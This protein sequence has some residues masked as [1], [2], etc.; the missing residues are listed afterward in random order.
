VTTSDVPKKATFFCEGDKS[1]EASFF[2]G[3]DEG[4]D[5]KLSDG[6][7]LSIP[8]AWSA[9]GARYANADESF[10]F[11]NKGNTAFV[12]EG[13]PGHETYSGCVAEQKPA[14]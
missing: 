6:R 9:S 10:V 2:P 1:I 5:L 12:T 8:H 13:R 4:V 14:G 11:W 3:N 7:N